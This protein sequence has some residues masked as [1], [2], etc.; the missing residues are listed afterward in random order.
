MLDKHLCPFDKI[1]EKFW[2]QGSGFFGKIG[3][4]FFTER[5]EIETDFYPILLSYLLEK[6]FDIL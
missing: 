3:L 5:I 2:D 4:T 6:I 1:E